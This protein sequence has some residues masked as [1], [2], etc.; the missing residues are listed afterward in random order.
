MALRSG[1]VGV[2]PS[3]VDDFGKIKTITPT[4]VYT[5]T[6]ADTKFATK[7]NTYTKTQVNS[8]VDSLKLLITTNITATTDTSGVVVL[9]SSFDQYTVLDIIPTSTNYY[10][11]RYFTG[12]GKVAFVAKKITDDTK[13]VSTEVTYSVIY[14]DIFK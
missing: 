11:S 1:R 13:L 9:D 8:L 4:D 10:I 7:S 14:S 3:E 12:S 5:K 2:A 6:E